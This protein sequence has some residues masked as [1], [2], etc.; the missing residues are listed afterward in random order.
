MSQETTCSSSGQSFA[1][2]WSGSWSAWRPASCLL[3]S[4]APPSTSRRRQDAEDEGARCCR[5]SPVTRRPPS[6]WLTR[7]RAWRTPT[8]GGA[9]VVG[10]ED[11]TGDLLGTRLDVE[12]LRHRVWERV[13]VAPAVEERQVRGVRLLVVLVAE[14]RTPV[15]DRRGRLRWRVGPHC[16]DVDRSEWWVQQQTR[17]VQDPLAAPSGRTLPDVQPAALVAVARLLE[18]VDPLLAGAP[19]REQLTRLG[20]LRPDERLSRA[21]ALLL[22]PSDNPFF[23][24]TVVDVEGGDV[25]VSAPRLRGLSLLEQVLAV[26]DRLDPVNQAVRGPL[27]LVEAPVR[28]LPPVA[29]REA[30]CNAVVHRDWTTLDPVEISWVQAD[31]VMTVS[32][33]G[34]FVG[35]VTPG[36]ALT[37]RY[38]RSPA[39]ADLFQALGLVE[40]GGLGVD[41][42]VREM[43]S[44]GHRPPWLREE[45]G[46][47]VRLRLSGGAPVLPVLSLVRRLQPSVR[48]R[49]TGVALVVATLMREPYVRPDLLVPVLQRD[50]DEVE[51]VLVAAEDCRV[52]DAPLVRRFKDVRVL[53][54]E[55]VR[56]VE[57]ARRTS[58]ASPHHLL[59][60]R[61]PSSSTEVVARWLRDHEAV[62]SGDVAR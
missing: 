26:E 43:V 56:V 1:S 42:M 58:G 38:A 33:P 52:D 16:V 8:G 11:A 31:A 14:A 62:T 10:V 60:Y 18:Q 44:L 22:C 53:G 51:E 34:G 40:K 57:Q 54:D 55:A 29:V 17:R 41:R 19:A 4:S 23:A 37:T 20:A 48:R 50:Q 6:T 25:V 21:A 46:P 13:D 12:W 28:S 27:G 7:W 61:R 45:P 32:S 3:Q 36:N 5:R 59:P 49:D 35:G 39:L 2:P 30:L 15:E 24:V 47:R 9:L